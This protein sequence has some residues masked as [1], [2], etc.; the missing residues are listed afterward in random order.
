[1]KWDE[2]K[3]TQS[4]QEEQNINFSLNSTNYNKCVMSKVFINVGYINRF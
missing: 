2:C 4:Y 3:R 1:M